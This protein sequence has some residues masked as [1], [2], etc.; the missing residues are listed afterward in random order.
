MSDSASIHHKHRN[1]DSS[2]SVLVSQQSSLKWLASIF[3]IRVTVATDLEAISEQYSKVDPAQQNTPVEYQQT[4]GHQSCSMTTSTDNQ[5]SS[6]AAST[7]HARHLPT[8]IMT[9]SS[10]MALQDDF[11]Q[12]MLQHDPHQS[13]PSLE[14][15]FGSGEQASIFEASPVRSSATPAP[16]DAWRDLPNTP[17]LVFDAD[18]VMKK[19]L[20][21]MN[22]QLRANGFDPDN[23]P[24]RSHHVPVNGHGGIKAANLSN[25][26]VEESNEE[27]ESNPYEVRADQIGL[28]HR[29]PGVG[30]LGDLLTPPGWKPGDEPISVHLARVLQKEAH[31]AAKQKLQDSI[32]EFQDLKGAAFQEASDLRN[33]EWQNQNELQK[34]ICGERVKIWLAGQEQRKNGKHQRERDLPALTPPVGNAHNPAGPMANSRPARQPENH[35]HFLPAVTLSRPDSGVNR[36]EPSPKLLSPS[37]LDPSLVPDTIHTVFQDYHKEKQHIQLLHRNNEQRMKQFL[38]KYGPH[39]HPNQQPLAQ[40]GRQTRPDRRTGQQA[41]RQAPTTRGLARQLQPQLGLQ[42]GRQGNKAEH[43]ATIQQAQRRPSYPTPPP[44]YPTQYPE[45]YMRSNDN[46]QTENSDNE[47][48]GLTANRYGVLPGQDGLGIFDEPSDLALTPVKPQHHGAQGS[49]EVQTNTTP[50]NTPSRKRRVPK[51][52][53]PKK[54]TPKSSPNPNG[55]VISTAAKKEPWYASQLAALPT[56]TL[57]PEAIR[58]GMAYD[59][60][61]PSRTTLPPKKRRR[62]SEP[63]PVPAFVVPEDKIKMLFK[64]GLPVRYT[65]EGPNPYL[66]NEEEHARDSANV[67]R[68]KQAK[69]VGGA[70]VVPAMG[71]GTGIHEERAKAEAGRAGSKGSPLPVDGPSSSTL[72]DYS[73]EGKVDDP[74][75]GTYGAKGK[76]GKRTSPRKSVLAK[77]VRGGEEEE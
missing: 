17:K 53:S 24:N 37:F 30:H 52:A 21:T 71:C 60:K 56:S 1:F 7:R 5:T 44:G 3:C 28:S 6:F 74:S 66:D 14:Q 20:E 65:G 22:D 51:K 18:Q 43:R 8:P 27:P 4:A 35:H 39:L 23:L 62:G 40:A 50:A 19:A 73:S 36:P 58:A 31:Q 25:E 75:D 9:R 33:E 15:V 77:R 64:S 72:S 49:Q 34:L 13:L 76:R 10:S 68:G 70:P 32:V 57:V 63:V 2:V 29:I 59:P 42:N 41:S 69:R 16:M 12:G 61:G 38:T 26:N 48:Q 55:S 46:Q 47:M 11:S 67:V 45:S 54:S